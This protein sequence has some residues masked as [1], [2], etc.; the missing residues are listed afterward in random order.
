MWPSSFLRPEVRNSPA[1]LIR[2]RHGWW[3]YR[4]A[5]CQYSLRTE[6]LTINPSLPVKESESVNLHNAYNSVL[7]ASS[8]DHEGPTVPPN[9]S[10]IRKTSHQGTLEE[11]AETNRTRHRVAPMFSWFRVWKTLNLKETSCSHHKKNE[12]A[13]STWWIRSPKNKIPISVPGRQCYESVL[14]KPCASNNRR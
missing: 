8:P 1:Q 14:R 2:S 3:P 6:F 9:N 4:R 11:T 12:S 7:I 13:F 5:L 10:S